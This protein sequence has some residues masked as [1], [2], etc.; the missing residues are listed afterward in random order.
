MAQKLFTQFYN[1][2]GYLVIRNLLNKQQQKT[3]INEVKS[4]E[5]IVNNPGYIYHYEQDKRKKK[6]L[7]EIESITNHNKEF[8]NLLTKT[9]IHNVISTIV[10]HPIKLYKETIK[11]NYPGTRGYKARQDIIDNPNSKKQITCM[12]NLCNTHID[13]GCLNFAPLTNKNIIL[14]NNNGF[15]TRQG[16]LSWIPVPTRLGDI[17]LFSSYIPYKSYSNVTH[18]PKKSIYAKYNII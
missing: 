6:V 11:Y 13:N 5:N 2:Y 14:H 4:I 17:V 16:K 18:K 7:C 15:I 9:E 1:R 10:G 12:I 8:Y 3:I